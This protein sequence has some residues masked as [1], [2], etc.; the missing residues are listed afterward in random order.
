MLFSNQVSKARFL[1]LQALSSRFNPNLYQEFT[2]SNTFSLPLKLTYNS[3]DLR[4]IS[5]SYWW[6]LTYE[7]LVTSQR[8]LKPE[9]CRVIYV[10]SIGEKLIK[11]FGDDYTIILR[12]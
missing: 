6:E 2:I 3:Y 5:I 12:I 11:I 10:L 4:N 7:G 8:L 1:H 9:T